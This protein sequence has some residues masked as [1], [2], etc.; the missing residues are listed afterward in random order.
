MATDDALNAGEPFLTVAQ[1][2]A[3]GAALRGIPEEMIIIAAGLALGRGVESGDNHAIVRELGRQP[4]QDTAPPLLA[5]VDHLAHVTTGIEAL[6]LHRW[7]D[8]VGTARGIGSDQLRR[9]CLSSSMLV[10]EQILVGRSREGREVVVYTGRTKVNVCRRLGAQWRDLADMV[11]IPHADRRT[12]ERGYE[13]QGVWEW[14]EDRGR[15]GEL[16]AVLRELDR[17]DLVA[18][19]VAEHQGR[20]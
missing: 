19:L 1:R 11:D 16:A 17:H 12:F 8:E 2:D 3:L 10:A 5:F 13:A 7:I 4:W 14:L 18:L 15:L 20:P 6:T 9:L